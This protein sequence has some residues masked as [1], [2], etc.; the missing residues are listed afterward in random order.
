L[1]KYFANWIANDVSIY[2][3]PQTFLSRANVDF[4]HISIGREDSAVIYSEF[5]EGEEVSILLGAFVLSEIRLFQDLLDIIKQNLFHNSWE[6]DHRRA[7]HD[8]EASI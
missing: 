3:Q 7:P 5:Q 1:A 6:G 8:R 4:I 2:K